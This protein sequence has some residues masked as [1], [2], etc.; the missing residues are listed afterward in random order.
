MLHG[1]QRGLFE[2]SFATPA[3]CTRKLESGEAEVG[4]VPSVELERLGLKVLAGAGIACRGPIRSILLVAKSPPE[5][6]RVLAADAGSRTS[7]VLARL[8]LLERYGIKPKLL[9]RPPEL[10]EMLEVA[11]AALIIGDPAL[12]LDITSLPFITLDLGQEWFKLTGLP[13]VFAVWAARPEVV[14]PERAAAF[15]ESCR[16]G[17]AH[18]EEIVRQQAAPRGIPEALARKYL[19]EYVIN[20]LGPE[21]YRGLQTFLARARQLREAAGN[22]V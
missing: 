11:D 21:E 1:A 19:C 5:Q 8:L 9:R 22:A 3:E 18:L 20:E 10:A 15:L 13:M 14:T 12:R 6:I 17:R 7:V 2:L 4:I 16:Y